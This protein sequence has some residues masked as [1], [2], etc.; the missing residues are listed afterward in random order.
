MKSS[1]DLLALILMAAPVQGAIVSF[2]G[3]VGP[4]EPAG[5]GPRGSSQPA[6]S[7]VRIDLVEEATIATLPGVAVTAPG[8]NAGDVAEVTSLQ[9]GRIILARVEAGTSFAV[10]SAAATALGITGPRSA[11]RARRIVASPQDAAALTRGESAS[12]RPDAP[13]ALLT[14]L[15]RKLAVPVA[16]TSPA[17]TRAAEPR[18]SSSAAPAASPRTGIGVQ[19]AALSDVSRARTLASQLGG[20]VVSAGGLHRVQL[21]PFASEPQARAA[22][23]VAAKRGYPDARLVT[24]TKQ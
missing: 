19:V 16:A 12:S 11:V 20:Q 4:Q 23:D 5:A 22:R 9:T 2:Q 14:A 24:V 10:S 3:V 1:A 18:R 7:E 17:P 6:G 13:P 15:R 8:L 21:G